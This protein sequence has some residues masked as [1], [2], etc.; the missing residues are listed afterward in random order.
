MGEGRKCACLCAQDMKIY[1]EIIF[2]D[3]VVRLAYL[4]T[5]RAPLDVS[6]QLPSSLSMRGL[7]PASLSVISSL[8]CSERKEELNRS[9]T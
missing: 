3:V 7:S 6:R 8:R 9:E 1:F 2:I 4:G 5:S